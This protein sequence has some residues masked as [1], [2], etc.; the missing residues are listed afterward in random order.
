MAIGVA[1]QQG[2]LSYGQDLEMRF[3]GVEEGL[4]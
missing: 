1:S 3:Q 2:W 4:M